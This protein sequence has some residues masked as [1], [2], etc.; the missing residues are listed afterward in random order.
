M[1]RPVYNISVGSYS[2]TR[3]NDVEIVKATNQIGNRATIKLPSLGKVQKDGIVSTIEVARAFAKSDVVVINC[4]FEGVLV[5]EEFR[6][7]VKSISQERGI[8]ILECLDNMYE[9]EKHFYKESF[10]NTT[11]KDVL[12]AILKP[13]SWLKLDINVPG[14]SFDTYYL[15]AN[16]KFILEEMQKNYGL[17][18]YFEGDTLFV[19]L[20]YTRV[21]GY[22][23][24]YLS[25]ERCNVAEVNQ[26]KFKEAS[27]TSLKIRAIR[28][29][30]NNTKIEKVAGDANATDERTLYTYT[31]DSS[32]LKE[33]AE[34]EIKKYVYDGWDGS[35]KSFFIPDIQPGMVAV[36]RDPLYD[37]YGSYFIESVTITGG[38]GGLFRIAK[39][40]IRV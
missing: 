10:K 9:L 17:D 13:F 20:P 3:L 26:L 29:M 8:V 38:T 32:K 40:G 14:I 18:I 5:Q 25:G 35:L 28:I 12:N 11:L 36:I 30:P 23:Y 2:F 4:G 39:I 33:W 21:K 7:F 16:G 27:S 1:Y 19:A 34:S 31:V 6:G 24:L 22:V 15:N 37:R